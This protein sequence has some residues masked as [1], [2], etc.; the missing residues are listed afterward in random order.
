MTD[1]LVEQKPKCFCLF[2]LVMGKESVQADGTIRAHGIQDYP[3]TRF[4]R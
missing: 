2:S 4:T 3:G 1:S